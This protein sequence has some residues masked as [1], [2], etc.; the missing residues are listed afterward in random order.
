MGIEIR[1]DAINTLAR[2]LASGVIVDNPTLI[3]KV[4]FVRKVTI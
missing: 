2:L 4:V 3:L 1:R